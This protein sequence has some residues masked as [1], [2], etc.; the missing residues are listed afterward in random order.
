MLYIYFHKRSMN[1]PLTNGT[2]VEWDRK[3][4]PDW[5]SEPYV[6]EIVKNL[7]KSEALGGYAVYSPELGSIP[8]T[9]LSATCRNIIMMYK[10][11]DMIFA[12]GFLGNNANQYVYDISIKCDVH[13]YM[14]HLFRFLPNQIATLVDCDGRVVTSF[15]EIKKAWIKEYDYDERIW[16][17]GWLPGQMERLGL[18]PSQG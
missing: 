11:V 8:V 17:H 7:D 18:K 12:S 2:N 15:E 4:N 3:F 10:Q 16:D 5:M 6:K 13:L 9:W 1:I 14:N